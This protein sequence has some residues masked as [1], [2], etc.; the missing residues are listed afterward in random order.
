[1]STLNKHPFSQPELAQLTRK[2]DLMGLWMLIST[3]G[4]I[5]FWLAFAAWGVSVGPVAGVMCVLLSIGMLGGRQLCLAIATHEAAHRT[6]F[7]TRALNLAFSDWLAARPIGLDVEKYRQHHLLHHQHTGTELDV[8]KSL[9][10]GLPTTKAALAR[11]FFRDLTFQTGIKFLIGRVMMDAGLMQWTVAPEVTRLPRKPLSVHLKLL[12]KNIAPFVLTN[13][14]LALSLAALG[15]AW[16]YCLWVAA[17]LTTYTLFIRIRALAEHAGTEMVADTLRNTRTTYAGWL[18]KCLIAP[19]NVNYHQEHHL[20][21]A[22][23]WFNLPKAHALLRQK[24]LVGK[25]PS[26]PEVLHSLST[27]V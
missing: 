2:S 3:W 1:M 12:V 21:A 25:P 14:M 8:D 17:Y 5:A 18:A 6:L 20:V 23:P 27:T 7:K 11:K 22:V 10:A 4:L 13:A 9:V 15:Y 19:L 24:G 26:Y 16:L